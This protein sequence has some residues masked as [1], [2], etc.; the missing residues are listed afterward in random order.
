[1]KTLFIRESI[2]KDYLEVTKFHAEPVLLAYKPT[3][4]V[5]E[6]TNKVI[7]NGPEY[8]FTSQIKSS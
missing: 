5:Q 7:I 1:M 8:E 3:I 2:F 6:I 4:K